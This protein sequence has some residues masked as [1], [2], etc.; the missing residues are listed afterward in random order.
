ME[1]NGIEM[2]ING[3]EMNGLKCVHFQSTK[4]EEEDDEDDDD[5]D[6]VKHGEKRRCGS[7]EDVK[8]GGRRR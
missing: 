5:D 1:L 6:D 4:K 2:E 3:N 8:L 7:V